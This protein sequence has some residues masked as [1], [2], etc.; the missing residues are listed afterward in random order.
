MI[1]GSIKVVNYL[2]YILET[3]S[4]SIVKDLLCE[5]MDWCV[6]LKMCDLRDSSLHFNY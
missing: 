3:F 1:T 6:S 4:L 2:G 5:S